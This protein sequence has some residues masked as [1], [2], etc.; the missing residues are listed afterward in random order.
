MVV[1]VR[2]EMVLGEQYVADSSACCSGVTQKSIS[3]KARHRL[4]EQEVNK[5][6]AILNFPQF[7][8]NP[9]QAICQ[10]LKNTLS[11]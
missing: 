9:I 3:N 1:L 8:E 7:Q 5:F 11:H 2:S 4:V 10:H 6:Q